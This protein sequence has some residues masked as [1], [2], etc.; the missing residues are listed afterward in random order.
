MAA[1]QQ[2]FADAGFPEPNEKQHFPD[3]LIDAL[4]ISRSQ[5]GIAERL[6]ELADARFE[7]TMVSLVQTPGSVSANDAYRQLAGVQCA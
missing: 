5:T 2:M 4:V 6:H 1:Y 7:E 3:T